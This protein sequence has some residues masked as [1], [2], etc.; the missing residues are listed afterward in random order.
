MR[1]DPDVDH[2]PALASA[3]TFGAAAARDR[4][5]TLTLMPRADPAAARCARS[6]APARESRSPPCRDRCRRARH[7]VH[8]ELE[9]A[10]ALARA[11]SARRRQRRLEHQHG[12]RS[13]APRPRSSRA[14]CRCRSPRRS[15]TA[16]RSA[17][18]AAPVA[19]SASH[20]SIAIAIARLHVEDAGPCRRP[21]SRGAACA[22]AGRRPHGVEV[23]EQ[24][25]AARPSP[26]TR[27]GGDRRGPCC[28][29]ARH[30]AAERRAASSPARRRSDPPP[31]CRCSAIPGAR[32]PRCRRAGDACSLAV[33]DQ[34]SCRNSPLPSPL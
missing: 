21:S 29:S 3:T 1:R 19:R 26:R 8:H 16:S 28:G 30:A 10:A 11:S 14:T 5:P 9:L 32:A 24:Q 4:R 34:T 25:D 12:S 23:A 13:A 7:A 15:S 33:T 17:D 27:R 31:P 20:R 18:A 22:R 6:G 2:A